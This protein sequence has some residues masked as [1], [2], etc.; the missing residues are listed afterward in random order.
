MSVFFFFLQKSTSSAGH[1]NP[2]ISAEHSDSTSSAGHSNSTVSKQPDQS[3]KLAKLEVEVSD[4]DCG[5]EY[6]TKI[7]PKPAQEK[8][9]NDLSKARAELDI[10]LRKRELSIQDVPKVE[11][12]RCRKKIDTLE[13]HLQRLKSNTKSA[14]KLRGKRKKGL[15]LIKVD[16]PD[17]AKVLCLRDDVGRPSCE[18]NQPQLFQTIIDIAMHGASADEKRRSEGLRSCRTLDD[19]HVELKNFGFSIGRTTVYYRLLPRSEKSIDG[20]RHVK[21]VPV[22][23]C[24]AQ[25]DLH[26]GHV[27]TW[28]A[29]ASVQHAEELA[30]TFPDQSCFLSVDDKCRVPIGITACVKQSPLLMHLSYRVRLPDHDFVKAEKHKLIPSVCAGINVTSTNGRPGEGKRVT[31]SGPTYISV[32]SGKHSSSTAASHAWDLD[33]VLQLSEFKTISRTSDGLIR[34]ILIVVSDG[35]PDENPRFEKVQ[36]FAIETF[37]KYDLDTVILVTN[38]PGRSAYNRVERRMAPLSRMLAGIVLPHNSYGS[39]LDDS[40]KTTDQELERKNFAAAGNALAEIW[41]EAVIDGFPVVSKFVDADSGERMAPAGQSESWKAVHTRGSQYTFQVSKCYDTN[42]C[43]LWRCKSLQNILPLR[44]LPRPVPVDGSL[45][46]N[47]EGKFMPLHLSVLMAT[48]LSQHQAYDTYLPSFEGTDTVRNRTCKG[49]DLYHCSAKAQ[50]Q[51]EKCCKSKAVVSSEEVLLMKKIRP[52]RIAARRQRA[53]M[54][55]LLND[56]MMYLD[57]EEVDLNGVIDDVHEEISIEP[58]ERLPVISVKKA[59]SPVWEDIEN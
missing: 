46:A 42:C 16:H 59:L 4:A 17:A 54:A 9:E 13:K 52:V 56:E 22:K 47:K 21:T 12:D 44:F 39:H 34:P 49:C 37:L 38:A 10:L 28:F 55:V 19:L 32:R 36:S 45:D 14:Q 2:T 1:S 23:L 5:E 51:H 43:K 48:G 7:R 57:E 58:D 30:A 27:N 29:L 11:L 20:K 50:K 25:S 33:Q 31:Y 18:V 35:G 8:T 15:E 40:G 41:N 3:K 24:R 6:H 26:S 53:L